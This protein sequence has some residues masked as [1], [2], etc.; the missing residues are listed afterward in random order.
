[1]S[2]VRD[3]FSEILNQKEIEE[4]ER[5]E[6]QLMRS[7]DVEGGTA[8][9]FTRYTVSATFLVNENAILRGLTINEAVLSL[10]S[11]IVGGGILSLPYAF[12][13]IGIPGA[14]VLLMAINFCA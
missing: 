1:M 10:I 4:S 14:L 11:V 7:S 6:T 8:P 2:S 3:Y 5:D 13:N 9:I 12:A